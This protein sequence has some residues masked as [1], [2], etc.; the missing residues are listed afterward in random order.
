MNFWQDAWL[1]IRKNK[2]ALVSIVVIVLIIIF[3]FVGPSISGYGMNEQDLN[4]TNLPPKIACLENISWLP[5]DG[6]KTNQ[7]EPLLICMHKKI[8]MNI[9][10]LEQMD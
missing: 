1:R 6:T 4:R 7:M 9:I 5:F 3:A 2:A 10:G 8:L